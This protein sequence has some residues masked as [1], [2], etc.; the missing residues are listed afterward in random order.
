[1]KE[2]RFSEFNDGVVGGSPE[3]Y[4]KIPPLTGKGAVDIF[5]SHAGNYYYITRQNPGQKT[6]KTRGVDLSFDKE[7]H[8]VIFSKFLEAEVKIIFFGVESD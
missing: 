8:A 5:A 3:V 2:I 4:E 1:M 6:R 7:G